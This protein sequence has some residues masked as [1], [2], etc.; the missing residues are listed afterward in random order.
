MIPHRRCIYVYNTG[1]Q[2]DIYFEA[3]DHNKLCLAHRESSHVNGKINEESKIKYIDLV[4]DQRN[5]C[6][7]FLDGSAQNQSKKL[8][9]EFKDDEEG[10]VF[11]KLDAHIAFIDKVLEDMKAR[12]HSTRAVRAEKLDNLSEEERAKLKAHKIERAMNPEKKSKSFKA[13]PVGNLMK[14]NNL[15]GN[16]AKDLLNMDVDALLA[17]FENA[18]LNKG[19]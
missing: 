5:Y 4:N 3:I 11:E 17:K 8:I 16:D 2:C 9:F 15:S 13:D 19:E 14:K 12:L 1:Q 10:S 6:Y 7:H 18:K